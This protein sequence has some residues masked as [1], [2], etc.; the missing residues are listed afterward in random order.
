MRS[1][2]S[3]AAISSG[4]PFRGKIP[5]EGGGDVVAV[6]MKDTSPGAEIHWASCVR[7]VLSGKRQPD[8]L[9]PGD[10]LMAARGSHYY[11]VLI[12][13]GVA[14]EKVRAVAAPHFFVISVTAS[15]VLPEYL[16]WL[17]NQSP[18]QRYLEQNAEGTLTKSI[19]RSVLEDTPIAVPTLAK[20]QAIV[21]LVRRILEEQGVIRRLLA[22]GEELMNAI[23]SD[24][25][26]SKEV[27]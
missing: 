16:A 11:A 7:T 9:R 20:Q 19:R 18:C 26:D 12:D 17:L 2:K 22:N 13:D 24:L 10:I 6:Q 25:T 23:A 27:S 3:I 21:G 1:L 14:R 5:E 4:Y 8:W 15:G